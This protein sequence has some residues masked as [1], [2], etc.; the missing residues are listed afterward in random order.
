MSDALETY[1]KLWCKL[2]DMLDAGASEEACD[3]VRDECEAP[4]YAMTEADKAE[5]SARVLERART[6]PCTPQ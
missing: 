6:K 1:W 3:K 5:F 2:D 4:W